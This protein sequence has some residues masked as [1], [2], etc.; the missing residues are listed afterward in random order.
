MSI[1]ESN[2]VLAVLDVIKSGFLNISFESVQERGEK[3]VRDVHAASGS[4]RVRLSD[5]PSHRL[6]FLH[7]WNLRSRTA[8]RARFSIG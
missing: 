2:G 8:L 4:T 7:F 1:G 3:A 5:D 6:H